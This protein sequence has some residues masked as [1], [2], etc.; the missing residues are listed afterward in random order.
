MRKRLVKITKITTATITIT[1]E[2]TNTSSDIYYYINFAN[3]ITTSASQNSK[4]T[5]WT[6]TADGTLS[7]YVW[8]RYKMVVTYAGANATTETSVT[9]TCDGAERANT[10][11]LD[12]LVLNGSVN[13]SVNGSITLYYYHTTTLQPITVATTSTSE[14]DRIHYYICFD[15]EKLST[16]SSFDSKTTT[17]EIILFKLSRNNWK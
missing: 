15:E 4:S 6:P 8:Q 5:T 10:D 1:T 11:E 2:A 3:S 17:N 9:V 16:S 7:V 13:G 12:A 14:D